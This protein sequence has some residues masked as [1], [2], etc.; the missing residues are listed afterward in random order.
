[1]IRATHVKTPFQFAI[2]SQLDEDDF[3]ERQSHQIE[4][5][6]GRGSGFISCISHDRGNQQAVWSRADL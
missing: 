2:T 3:V 1:M 6:R 5:L 4:G